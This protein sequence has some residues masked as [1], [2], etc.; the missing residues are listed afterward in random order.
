MTSASREIVSLSATALAHRI[1]RGE[2]SS[3]E[4][5]DAHIERIEAVNPALN[6]VVVKRY[7]EARAEARAADARRGAGEALPPLHGVP[8]T[9]KECLDLTGTPSTFGIPSRAAHRAERDEAHVARWRAAGAIVLA[10]TN[11]SQLLC[12]TEADN[13]LYGRTNNPWNPLRSCGGSS[14]GEGAIIAAGGSPLGLGTD[15]GGSVRVPAAFCGIA[16]LKPTAGRMPD[17]GRYSFPL[18]QTAVPSQVG[19]MAREVEDVALGFRAAAAKRADQ[20]PIGDWRAVEIGKLRVGYYTDDGSFET[21]PAVRRGV[22]EAVQAL[23][24]AGAQVA[25]W[26]PPDGAGAFA[27]YGGLLTADGGAGFR[28]ALG[29]DKRVVQVAQL[30]AVAGLPA[31]LLP[32]LRALLRGLGQG[33]LARNLEAFGAKTADR[34]WTLVE[35]QQDYRERIAQSLDRA[36]IGSLDLIVAPACSLPA[37]THGA[38]R[39]LLTGGGYATLYNL[40]GYPAGVVPVTRVQAG[41]ESQRAASGDLLVKLARK[42]EQGS[43]GLPVGVQIIA[44]PWQEHVALAAMRAIEQAM[45]NRADFPKTPVSPG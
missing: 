4:A 20:P 28:R 11:V 29:R 26:T 1:A 16:S 14:G 13:P 17:S 35:A 40:L 9:V 23:R 15:I 19:P 44:R 39:D 8:C 25:P 33:G 12:F 42:V 3:L 2:L 21:A 6:A 24:G 18:G 7:D 36:D 37:F 34:Y 45:R 27:L 43:A 5:V 32:A 22:E 10:K 41:E 38:T 31:W 30:L